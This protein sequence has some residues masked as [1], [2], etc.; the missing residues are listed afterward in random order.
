MANAVNTLT[1]DNLASRPGVRKITG[2]VGTDGN[3]VVAGGLSSY[4]HISIQTT[5]SAFDSL[6]V[7]AEISNNGV[8]YV[9]LPTALAFSAAGIKFIPANEL[10]FEYLR[11]VMTNDGTSSS[12]PFVVVCSG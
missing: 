4:D 12:V 10:G 9:A 5:G 6:I 11:F 8:D 7:T 1:L 3:F 2:T